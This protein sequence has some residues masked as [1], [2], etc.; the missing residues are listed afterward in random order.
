MV[1]CYLLSRFGGRVYLLKN[2][3][4]I[5]FFSVENNSLHVLGHLIKSSEINIDVN[6]LLY[7]SPT[8]ILKKSCTYFLDI[9]CNKFL[10]Q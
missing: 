7:F 1:I 8:S 5:I 3:I 4:I 6:D 9:F 2:L 10:L